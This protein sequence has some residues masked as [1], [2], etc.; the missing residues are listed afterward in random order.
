MRAVPSILSTFLLASAAALAGAADG[1]TGLLPPTAAEQAWMDANLVRVT[2]VLPNRLAMERVAEE[3]QVQGLVAAADNV[4]VAEDGD[5]IVGVKGKDLVAAPAVGATPLVGAYPR[6]V[7]N[8]TAA[9][10]PPIGSQRGGSCASF[11]TTYYTMTSQVARLRGWSV[12]TDNVDAHKFSTRFIYNLV[13]N[14]GDNGSWLTGPYDVMMS[15]GCAT[16]QTV[17]Y[18]VDDFV[19]WPTSAATWREAIN[20]R[21]AESGSVEATDG[22]VGRANAKQML[23]DGYILNYATHIFDWQYTNFKNDPATSADDGLFAAGV[24]AIRIKVASHAVHIEGTNSGHGMTIVGYNDDVWCDLNNNGVVDAGEKGAFRIANSWGNYEDGGFIWVSYDALKW[25]SGVTNGPNPAGRAAIFWNGSMYWMSARASYTPTL[26]AEITATHAKRDQMYLGV[27]CGAINATT[28]TTTWKPSQLQGSGGSWAFNGTT[29]PVAATFVLDCTDL[30]SAGLPR[31]FVSLRDNTPG[32]VAT[33]SSARMVFANGA[34]ADCT[35]TNP[36]GGLA[37]TVDNATLYAMTANSTPAINGQPQNISVS[38]G[39]TA[40]F[41]VSATGAAPMNYQWRR[42]GSAIGGATSTSYSISSTTSAD[43]GARF[44]VLVSN[45]IG[46]VTSN[47]VLLTVNASGGPAGYTWCANEWGSVALNG[48][49]DVAYGGNGVFNYKYAQTGTITFNN[50]TFGDPIDGVAKS[51][52]YKQLSAPVISA[53]PQGRSVTVGQAASFSVSAS[54]TDTLAYQWKKNGSV[55]S[56]ATST[57]YTTP[58]TTIADNGAL[59]TVVVSNRA[60]SVTSGAA[61]LT[62]TGAAGGPAGYTW[63]AS[64]GGNFTLSGICDVAYG[65][66]GVFNYKYN[67]TGT[68]T[69]NNATFGDPIDGVTKAG[70]YRV[71]SKGTGLIGAYFANTSLAGYPAMTRLDATLDFD[72]GG[73]APDVA[74]GADAFSV[75][76]SGK[77][78]P[79]FSET[80][81]FTTTSDDG[82]RLWVNGQLIIDNWTLHSPTDNS[83]QIA[84]SAGVAVDLRMEYFDNSGYALAKLRWQSASQAFQT[85]PANCL[86]PADGTGLVGNYFA[87]KGL[88]GSPALTRL[89]ATI[90]FDWGAGSPA[91][92]ISADLFSVRWSGKVLPRYSETYT[93]TTSSDDGVRLWVNGVMLV[94]NWGDHSLVDNSNLVALTAGVPVDLRMEYYDNSGYAV[95]KLRWQSASQ[96]AEIV[97]AR[98]LFPSAGLLM[99]NVAAEDVAVAEAEAPAQE[100]AD[101]SKGCGLGSNI[102]GILGLFFMVCL[103]LRLKSRA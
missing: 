19:S 14:G 75:R 91:S 100:A 48:V 25:V 23:A 55:I 53:Q 42:N 54:G 58:A 5:E 49:C 89:D 80:Y 17:P 92:A 87:N 8:S 12:K 72:W 39:Q 11:S 64:E 28:P 69:F 37:R 60:G 93:F 74:V 6:A 45:S 1:P 57:S 26:V 16:Y 36:S 101:E 4:T 99:V 46:S 96:A 103:R 38:V 95:A 13:N 66:N 68:V 21:M 59:F 78:L 62:V 65:G 2:S 97:P 84:L 20:Y 50:A 29:T 85:V 10:F 44:S 34:I 98:C 63:C 18:N 90:A 32:N 79:R 51:G 83:G 88:T 24:P 30:V 73:S 7:D 27:G 76:W 22:D 81:T 82:V 52:Y 41:S 31:W 9:W 3:R 35:V 47:E 67:Q 71:V 15:M 43:N 70:Y 61:L 94:N 77:V 33:L 56:G 102:A 86:F 40:T